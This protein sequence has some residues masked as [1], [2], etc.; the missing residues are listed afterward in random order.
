MGCALVF[1][2]MLKNSH[3]HNLISLLR[4]T[5]NMMEPLVIN[6]SQEALISL[7]QVNKLICKFHF[8]LI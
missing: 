2:S 3:V 5:K 7:F 8:K 1:Y 4:T 6:E